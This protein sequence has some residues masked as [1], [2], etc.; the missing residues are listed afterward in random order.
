MTAAPQENSLDNLRHWVLSDPSLLPGSVAGFRAPDQMSA[1]VTED[2]TDDGR[3]FDEPVF[4]P[5]ELDGVFG[6][7]DAES[8]QKLFGYVASRLAG[9]RAISTQ[10]EEGSLG[11]IGMWNLADD[12]VALLA[13]DTNGNVVQDLWEEGCRLLHVPPFEANRVHG[14]AR[15]SAEDVA[16]SESSVAE[17]AREL[18]AEAPRPRRSAPGIG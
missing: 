18:M 12:R 14:Q 16:R 1:L 10:L 5:G 2:V 15:I 3:T 4:G 9:K 8:G 11:L 17:V 13:G 6:I 7:V